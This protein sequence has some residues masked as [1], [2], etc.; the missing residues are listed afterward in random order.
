MVASGN[1]V[2]IKADFYINTLANIQ[3][4]FLIDL[5]CCSCWDVSSEVENQCP[6]VRLKLSGG[7]DFLSIERGK[8]AANTLEQTT[9]AFPKNEWCYC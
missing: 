2:E 4:L 8:I 9:F 5:E 6:G 1:T 3:D 7:N